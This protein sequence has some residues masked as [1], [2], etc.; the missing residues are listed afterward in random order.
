MIALTELLEWRSEEFIAL[1]RCTDYL[2]ISSKFTPDGRPKTTHIPRPRV[3]GKRAST[4][5]AVP[6]LPANCYSENWKIRVGEEVVERMNMGPPMDLHIPDALVKC[7]VLV[8]PY[9]V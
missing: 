8:D 7:V 9:L 1:L 6:D 2:Y 5:D 4:R 3:T